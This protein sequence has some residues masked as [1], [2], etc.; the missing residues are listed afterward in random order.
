MYGVGAGS[1]NDNVTCNGLP[2]NPTGA[3]LIA[4]DP[5]LAVSVQLS[6]PPLL[7]LTPAGTFVK[8]QLATLVIS[9]PISL[10]A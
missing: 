10:T 7:M 5:P 4:N 9:T 2:V 6:T 8:L 3:Q 1:I